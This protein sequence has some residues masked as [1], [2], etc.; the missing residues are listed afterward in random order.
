M[1]ERLWIKDPSTPEPKIL[2]TVTTDMLFS[3]SFDFL[4]YSD[5]RLLEK[6][7][8]YAEE[9]NIDLEQVDLLAF[10]MAGYRMAGPGGYLPKTRKFPTPDGKWIINAFDER[11]TKLAYQ[12]QNGKAMLST[13]FDRG[14][15][16]EELDPEKMP[17]HGVDFDFFFGKDG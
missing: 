7:Y 17:T 15:L 14:F 3:N 4:T 11:D 13:E 10:D 8:S 6:V 5:R 1:L 2:Y 12:I 9:N 16:N